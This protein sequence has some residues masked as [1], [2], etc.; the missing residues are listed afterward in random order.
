MLP[1]EVWR[2]GEVGYEAAWAL[3]QRLH[4]A[5]AAGLIPDQ[6]LLLSHPHTL[7]VG[8]RSGK[9]DPWENLVAP[10]EA[11]EALGVAL[12]LSDRGGDITWHGPGQLVGYPIVGLDAYDRDVGRFVRRVEDTVLRSLSALGIQGRRSE[13]FPGVWIGD[14]KIAAVGARIRAWTT[15]HGFSLNVSGGLEG[16]GWIVPCGLHGRGVTSLARLVPG[17]L[18]DEAAL[19]ALV[20]DAAA[21]AFDRAPLVRAITSDA[22]WA[23]TPEVSEGR[24][25]AP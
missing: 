13:G 3:Q 10:R 8:T 22:L 20:A 19:H 23:R 7:T 1:L 4:A 11:L 6:L 16:F 17:P 5:R 12:V 14:Q 18:P 21:A 24:Q 25:G 2:L 9:P 15:M